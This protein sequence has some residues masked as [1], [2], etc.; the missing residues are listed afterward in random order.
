MGVV[1]MSKRKI[2]SRWL[3]PLKMCVCKIYL[4]VVTDVTLRLDF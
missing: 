4:L 3:G 1:G 2:V